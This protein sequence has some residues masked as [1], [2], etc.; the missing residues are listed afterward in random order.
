MI[1]F[2]MGTDTDVGK[3]FVTALL[4]RG[5]VKRGVNTMIQKWVSTGSASV[6]G[7]CRFIREVAG[8]Q[9]DISPGSMACP[10]CLE[11]PASPHLSA[12]IQGV[13]LDFSKIVSDMRHLA[14]KCEILLI[15]GVGGGLV[16]LSRRVLLMDMV[17]DLGLPVLIVARSGLGTLNHTLLT[18]EALKNRNLEILGV[19][20]NST[21]PENPQIVE[22]NKRT[23]AEFGKVQVFGPVPR[24]DRP[25]EAQDSLK[26]AVDRIVAGI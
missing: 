5:L 13:E 20:L 24:T 3:T 6:A 7:D 2:V 11:F 18:I 8:L 1:V 21:G 26:Q 4:A 17:A 19:V 10:Y 15:E 9:Q 14:S 22:D 16:P 23:I 25:Q 12:E